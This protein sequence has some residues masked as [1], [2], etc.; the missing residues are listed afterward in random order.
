[1]FIFILS[2]FF[3]SLLTSSVSGALIFLGLFKTFCK[4]AEIKPYEPI[5]A[6]LLLGIAISCAIS[7]LGLPIKGCA[8]IY[9]TILNSVTGITVDYL[10]Y[11]IIMLPFC[12][13][14]LLFFVL[15]SKYI[16]KINADCMSKVNLSKNDKLQISNWDKAALI[17]I[18]LFLIALMLPSF[19]TNIPGT[20]FLNKIGSGGIGLLYLVICS[21][22]H[23]DGKPLMEISKIAPAVTWDMWFMCVAFSPV[24]S[25]LT[26]EQTGISATL[27]QLITPLA[28]NLS[29]IL[30]VLIFG[31]LA[32][33]ITQIANNAVVAMVFITIVGTI[34]SALQGINLIS[35]MLVIG[36]AAHLSCVLPSANM[37]IGM[38]YAQKDWV[39]KGV[40]LKY[41]LI[42]CIVLLLSSIFLVYP[43]SNIIF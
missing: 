5:A 40:L 17:S 4:S 28:N 6:V 18:A 25:A 24:T 26:N 34:S 22:V 14:F 42:S 33:V 21:A 19:S 39:K 12:I 10:R 11:T 2:C 3:V 1:M 41:G 37:I 15:L 8:L 13:V 43:V 38:C 16:L 9:I 35:L 36:C 23:I 7:E 31:I 32:C 27:S 30:I 20:A 29:P